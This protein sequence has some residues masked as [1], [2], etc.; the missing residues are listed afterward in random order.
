MYCILIT[1]PLGLALEGE[2]ITI[3]ICVSF[4]LHS[5]CGKFEG[6]GPV[7]R[8]NHSSEV[9]VAYVTD[10]PKSA[11]N[12]REIEVLCRIYVVNF[13]FLLTLL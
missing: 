2:L 10:H 1:S 13:I 8:F 6:Y 3:F 7:N 4:L 5:F 9:A 12:R 11:C